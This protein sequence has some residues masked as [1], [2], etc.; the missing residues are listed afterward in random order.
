M[1]TYMQRVVR[2]Y[3]TYHSLHYTLLPP[4]DVQLANPKSVEVQRGNK[5]KGKGHPI[6]DHQRSR[7]RVE[8]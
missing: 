7:G 4:D 3:N 5:D 2:T 1:Y 6:T 8:V